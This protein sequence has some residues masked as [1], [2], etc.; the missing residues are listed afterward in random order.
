MKQN[1]IKLLTFLLIL[2][3][4]SI[5]SATTVEWTEQFGTSANEEAVS[6]S[7]DSEIVSGNTRGNFAGTN[8]GDFDV[9]LIK[10]D[11]TGSEIWRRQF[12]SSLNDFS[13]ANAVDK[14]GNIHLVGLTAATLPGQTSAGGIDAFIA[15]YNSAGTLQFIKQFGTTGVDELLGAA[16]DSKGNLITVGGTTGSIGATNAGLNDVLIRK[17]D[18]NG[19]V[20]WTK[21]FG[22]SSVD[23]AVSVFVGTDDKIYVAGFTFGN[24]AATN[25]GSSDVF[26]A[27]F[28]KNGDQ[29]FIKQFGT[30]G[31]DDI[32]GVSAITAWKSKVFYVAGR[33]TGNLAKINTGGTDVFIRKFDIKGN[34]IWTKQFGSNDNDV[35]FTIDT[36]QKKDVYFGG[37]TIKD[38]FGP[39]LTGSSAYIAKIDEDG[40]LLF[41]DQFTTE[42]FIDAVT[43]LKVDNNFDIYATGLTTGV[44]GDISFGGFDGFLRKYDQNISKRQEVGSPTVAVSYNIPRSG[45]DGLVWILIIGIAGIIAIV[46]SSVRN[47]GIKR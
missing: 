40:N 21:Q 20:L 31:L 30:A 2:V 36:D 27:K 46:I 10:F 7:L 44:L 9:Y 34:E 11:S 32:A 29:L 47:S 38:L 6:V 45:S 39:D 3:T 26:V 33:T 23:S 12:G 4:V 43:T 18:N 13:Q 37:F 22:T 16:I 15:K 41:T 14:E 28:K 35:V 42:T 25:L 8:A 24:L 5:V 19:N 17:F 1:K